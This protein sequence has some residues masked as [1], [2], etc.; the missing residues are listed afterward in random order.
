MVASAWRLASSL[1]FSICVVCGFFAPWEKGCFAD[2]DVL[3]HE[4]AMEVKRSATGES[5]VV[6]IMTRDLNVAQS[7]CYRA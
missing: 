3:G 5:I 2:K 7:P 6:V 1:N 4:M